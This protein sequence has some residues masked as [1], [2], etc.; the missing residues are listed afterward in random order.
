MVPLEE[1]RRQ[2]IN[3]P[4]QEEVYLNDGRTMQFRQFSDVVGG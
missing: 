2:H 1:Q 3:T 4:S